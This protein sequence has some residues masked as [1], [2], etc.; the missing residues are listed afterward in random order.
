M[1]TKLILPW[2]VKPGMRLV[3]ETMPRN[4][5]RD[6]APR[7]FEVLSVQ[8]SRSGFTGASVWRFTLKD[9]LSPL[10]KRTE[11]FYGKGRSLPVQ[12]VP[13]LDI[14]KTGFSNP[15]KLPVSFLSTF[16]KHHDCF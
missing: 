10:G 6:G 4:I 3:L 11:I 9:E 12:K 1:K 14:E 7:S 13:V 16:E 15:R 8:K 5:A 2:Q